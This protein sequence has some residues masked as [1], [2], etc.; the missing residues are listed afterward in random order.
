MTC[1]RVRPTNV[2]KVKNK[3]ALCLL[4]DDTGEEY[5]EWIDV[6]VFEKAELDALNST[7]SEEM[8]ASRRY[9]LQQ[10]L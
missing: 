5:S 4:S 10:W 9:N 6:E 1:R 2:F 3:E 7:N 8:Y